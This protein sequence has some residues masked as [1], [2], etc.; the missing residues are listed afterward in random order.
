M[1]KRK[2]SNMSK[3]LMFIEA[4]VLLPLIH[5]IALLCPYQKTYEFSKK[6][7]SLLLR[8]SPNK[9]ITIQKNLAIIYPHKDFS[10]EELD[11][12]SR[13]IAGY[14][15]RIIVEM[16]Q[17]SRMGFQ[18]KISYIRVNSC[19]QISQVYH[20]KERNFVGFTLHCGN[21]EILGC[22]MTSV[23]IPMTCLVER[24]FN[25]WIDKHIQYLRHELGIGT[26]YN[27]ISLMRPL[28]DCMKKG[29]VVGLVADQTHWFDP[30]FIPFFGEEAA[31]PSGTAGLAL[32]MKS[33]LFSS[34]SQ[35]LGKGQ[36]LVDIDTD[37]EAVKT[38]DKV[39]DVK[40]L[41]EKIY[42]KYE[43]IIKKD[44]KNWYTLGT[45]RWGLTRESLKEWE[46][47]PDSD[48]F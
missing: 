37:I 24:Q 33:L 1:A 21:W 20:R 43:S 4:V 8:L 17:F 29:G 39:Q 12:I 10:D 13:V 25:P 27:E 38:D 44:V 19:N 28:L 32:K 42:T 11:D 3:V 26:I 7:G 41:M 15:L 14:E 2:F 34:Y 31:V 48:R 22:F 46:K 35:Y 36:Y 5:V 47:N 16:I 40:N 30:L 23:G 6:I 18:E 45:D 9:K